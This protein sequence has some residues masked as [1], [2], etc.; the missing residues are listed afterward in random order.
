MAGPPRDPSPNGD[1]GR[2][3]GSEGVGARGFG[4]FSAIGTADRSRGLIVFLR[5]CGDTDRRRILPARL[6]S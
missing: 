3:E 4:V 5:E 2:G 1:E 6:P